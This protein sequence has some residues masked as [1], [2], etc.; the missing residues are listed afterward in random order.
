MPDGNVQRRPSFRGFL[1][2]VCSFCEQQ[3]GDPSVSAPGRQMDGVNH[4]LEAQV[5]AEAAA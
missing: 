3:A 2:W 4:F 5:Q 1:R